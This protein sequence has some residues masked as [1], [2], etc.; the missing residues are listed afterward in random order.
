MGL[1]LEKRTMTM[2]RKP[3]TRS[4]FGTTEP[5]AYFEL[6]APA[7]REVFLAGSFNNWDP[8]ATPMIPLGHGRWGKELT[9]KPGSYEY[10]FVVDGQWMSDPA[11]KQSVPNPY[12][13]S[14][15]IMVVRAKAGTG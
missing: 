10:R 4:A 6:V 11:A 12:G 14:N 9:L 3:R 7:A 15:S 13:E 2:P 1:E 5:S 8:T